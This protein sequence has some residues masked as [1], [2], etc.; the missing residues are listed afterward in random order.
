[1]DAVGLTQVF[2]YIGSFLQFVLAAKLFFTGLHKTYPAFFFLNAFGAARSLVLVLIVAQGQNNEVYFW[3]WFLTE[4]VQLLA[5]IL[6]VIEVYNQSFRDYEG[7]RSLSRWLFFA[8]MGV[9]TVVSMLSIIPEMSG[10][11]ES[12]FVLNVIRRSLYTSMLVFLMLAVCAIAYFPV[13]LNRN[14]V[15][16]IIAYFLGF[17]LFTMGIYLVNNQQ[18]AFVDSFNLGVQTFNILY[19]LTLSFLLTPSG[20][21]KEATVRSTIDREE[22]QELLDRLKKVNQN[23]AGFGKNLD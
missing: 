4:P 5:A 6:V 18:Y 20:E 2:W 21:R 7:I 23:L 19:F 3:A 15:T 12:F 8:A 14:L 17:I 10:E 16:Y 9:A 22:A 1:M 13:K 11:I